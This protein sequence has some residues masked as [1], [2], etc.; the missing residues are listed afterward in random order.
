[1]NGEVLSG[2]KLADVLSS[3]SERKQEYVKD[4]KK[5]IE[6]NNFMKFDN[7]SFVN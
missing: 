7:S 2:L 6:S 3:Y 4:V 1:M 5:I